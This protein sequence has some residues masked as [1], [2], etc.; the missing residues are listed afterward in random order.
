MLY[1]RGAFE[2]WTARTASPRRFIS[3]QPSNLCCLIL[4]QLSDQCRAVATALGNPL[5]ILELAHRAGS[6]MSAAQRDTSQAVFSELPVGNFQD[7]HSCPQ[8]QF[9]TCLSGSWCA[10]F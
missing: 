8:T 10:Q 7:W 1:E 2:R 5:R 6:T 9:V 3:V 4:V